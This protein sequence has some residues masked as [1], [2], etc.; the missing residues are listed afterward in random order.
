MVLLISTVLSFMSRSN[1]N[2][3]KFAFFPSS[4]FDS[5]TLFTEIRAIRKGNKLPWNVAD[6]LDLCL[7]TGKLQTL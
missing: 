3:S 6:S 5:S 7:S 4:C 2:C 1:N